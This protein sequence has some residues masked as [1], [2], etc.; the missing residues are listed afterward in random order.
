MFQD[1]PPDVY[2]CI[3]GLC[4]NADTGRFPRTPLL[5]EDA[6]E[7][8]FAAHP[9]ADTVTLTAP[10]TVTVESELDTSCTGSDPFA[11]YTLPA[12]CRAP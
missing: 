9:R 10:A 5:R 6:E 8:C 3:D 1:S 7:L 2:D 4:E 11:T 12:D